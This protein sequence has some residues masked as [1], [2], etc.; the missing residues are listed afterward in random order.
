MQ[1]ATVDRTSPRHDAVMMR[2]TKAR[3]ILLNERSEIAFAEPAAIEL[4]SR[5]LQISMEGQMR[6]PLPIQR[7]IEETA[8]SLQSGL[9]AL[10]EPVPNLLIRVVRLSGLSGNSVVALHVECRTQRQSLTSAARSYKLTRRETDVLALILQGKPTS[11]VA[12]ELSISD[13]TAADYVKKLLQK[14]FSKSRAEMLSK[15]LDWQ[16]ETPRA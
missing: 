8:R 11:Q 10:I 12:R 5:T 2:R 4:L 16:P 15:I 13:T 6:F 14:T 7:A 3:I 9:D 1:D